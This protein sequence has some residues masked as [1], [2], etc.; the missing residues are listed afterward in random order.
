MR[1]IQ[2]S[3][4]AEAAE[5]LGGAVRDGRRVVVRGGGTKADW[6]APHT[7]A[8][9]TLSTVRM[10]R[11]LAHRDGDLTATIEAGARLADVNRELARHGQW[12][13]LDPAWCAHATIGGIVATND[14]GPRRH[15]YGTPRDQVIGVEMCRA[16]GTRAKAGGIVVKNVA[17]YDLARLLTGS[18]GCL[19]VILSATFKLYPV[20]P[21]SRT[22]VA[23]LPTHAAA[24]GLAAALQ[25]GELTPT[26]VEI[27]LP[28]LRLLIRFESTEASTVTQS[29]SAV[30]VAESFGAR[31]HVLDASAEP[32]EWQAHEDRIW[33]APGA[34]VKIAL[35]PTGLAP[36]LDLFASSACGPIDVA[37]RAGLGVLLVR[38][39]GRAADQAHLIATVRER[40][41]SGRGSAVVL[42][43]SDELR[44]LV[45]P[46]GPMG[47]AF[48]VM[49][50]IKRAFDP[51]GL[52]NP[53][54][55][56]GGL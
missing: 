9:V 41:A 40:S 23:E 14:A 30:R 52:L 32:V 12:I 44:A 5:A 24:A 39:G 54:R 19:G 3:D 15:R 25:S 20:A 1:E 48:R 17:G 34:V 45:D 36:M 22:V 49:Q 18:F 21:S 35:L 38:L 6:M 7:G 28:P 50:S 31:A 27:Q 33:S 51:S 47:D 2:P 8:D 46:W 56:P 43:A 55:G 4:G 13:A 37:G 10:N 16:D 11:L 29:A 42:R 53:G 26:A